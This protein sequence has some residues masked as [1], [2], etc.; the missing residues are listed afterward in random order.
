VALALH[1]PG[2]A[3]R[4]NALLPLL[5]GAAL[6]GAVEVKLLAA[7]FVVP[8]ILVLYWRRRLLLGA[9]GFALANALLLLPFLFRLDMV[10]RQAVSSHVDARA[11]TEGGFSADMRVTLVRETVLVAL[12]V[13]GAAVLLRRRADRVTVL[14]GAWMVPVAALVAVQHPLWPHHLLIAVPP[15][16]VAAGTLANVAIP[17]AVAAPLTAVATAMLLLVGERA[18]D[19]PATADTVAA[20]VSVLHRVTLPGDL[21]VTDDPFSAAQAGLDTPPELVDTSVVRLRSQPVTA[22]QVERI[23]REDRVRVVY[24]G[25]NRLSQ[26]DGLLAWV[27]E[28]YPQRIDVGRSAVVHVAPPP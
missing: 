13:M 22:A 11:L 2:R 12:A 6:A 24:L 7:V 9:A 21:V 23:A 16:A 20:S 18:L 28:H 3:S 17:R 26:L 25:T 5:S 8:V 4:W 1:Q 27:D 10:W 19:N 14:L 15:L